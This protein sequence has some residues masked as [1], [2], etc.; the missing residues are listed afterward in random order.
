MNK[1]TLAKIIKPLSDFWDGMDKSKKI[2]FVSMTAVIVIVIIVSALLLSRK[3]Y[4][5]LYN[6]MD[7]K[8]AGEVLNKLKEMDVDAKVEGEGTI[9]VPGGNHDS[10]RMQL[11]A[12]GY[13]KSGLNYDVFQNSTGFGTTEFEK[14]KYLQF[15]LQE[16]LQNAIKSLNNVEDAIVTLN[17]SDNSSFVLKEDKQDTTASVIIKL[18]G[19]YALSGKQIKGIEG[20][21]AKSVPGLAEDKVLIIDNMGNSLKSDTDNDADIAGSKLELEHKTGE[22]IQHQVLSL[23]EPVFGVGKVSV[24]VRVQ[25]DFDKQTTESI[26]YDPV[27]D[28][29]EGIAVSANI[30][31]EIARSDDNSGNVGQDPNGGAP[32]YVEADSNNGQ[33]SKTSETINYEVNKIKDTIQKAEGQIKDISISV[34]LDDKD[35]PAGSDGKV[36]EIVAGAAGVSK[37]KVTVQRMP[38]N[39]AAGIDN[40]FNSIERANN[41]MKKQSLL[42][43][44]IIY[45]VLGML[46]LLVLNFTVKPFKKKDDYDSKGNMLDAGGGVSDITE[47]LLAA[48]DFDIKINKSSKREFVEKSIEKRPELVAQ[49][50]RNWLTDEMR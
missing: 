8:E 34:L 15:Q 2:R 28:G 10:L 18:K 43:N 23:L 44:A 47:D 29:S 25:L 36:L 49:L 35:L 30:E 41:Q 32:Q 19:S 17:I 26:K 45:G 48:D 46:I 9:L 27:G 14:Q 4:T 13:P 11:A 16:R 40:I 12:E 22:K 1:E 21:V 3:E 7:V 31:N 39:G 38:F 6:N 50:L 33:Y 42:R 20:L 37:D 5:V 24:G